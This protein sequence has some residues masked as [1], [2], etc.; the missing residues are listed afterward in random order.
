[1]GRQRWPD[2]PLAPSGIDVTDRIASFA[3]TL[4]E[5]R[6]LHKQLAAAMAEEV[7]ALRALTEEATFA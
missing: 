7:T 3:W 4:D 2:T 5:A 6:T 1:M